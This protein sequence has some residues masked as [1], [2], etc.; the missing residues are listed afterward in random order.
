MRNN[1]TAIGK[2]GC[3]KPRIWR[4]GI[5]SVTNALDVV[6]Q[7]AQEFRR[8]R[9]NVDVEQKPHATAVVRSLASHAP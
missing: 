1:H 8:A 7:A 9:S 6:P 2:G 4:A 5:K 3:D